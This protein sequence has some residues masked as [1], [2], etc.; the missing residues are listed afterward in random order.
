MI[1]GFAAVAA[2]GY[3]LP[4][5][6]IAG[7]WH[8][9]YADGGPFSLAVLVLVCGAALALRHRRLFS[10]MVTGVVATA[11]AIGTVAPVVLAHLFQNVTHGPG[12][13]VFAIGVLGLFFGGAVLFLAE[14]V[15]YV[16]ERRDR[17]RVALMPVAR[18]LA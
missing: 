13:T 18:V 9:N 4:A 2:V 14:P 5:H 16:L 3:L 11:G 1:A 10:G 17:M 6:E 8:S 7:E 12:E 15:L